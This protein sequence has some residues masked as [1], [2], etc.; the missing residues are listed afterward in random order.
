MFLISKDG[1]QEKI[2]SDVRDGSYSYIN[3]Q[4]KVLFI[5]QENEL[6]EF[7]NGKEKVKLAKDVANFDGDYS[8]D[9]VT[10]QNE[11]TDLYIINGESEKEK[12]SS[13]VSQ[14][15]LIGEHI[16]FLDNDGDLSKYN[17]MIT[18]RKKLQVM[19]SI[20]QA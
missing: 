11:E 15:E 17:T 4:D 12:I 3:S 18:K 2:A 19:F 14:Y 20:L 8:E 9:I 5:N 10:F 13:T 16:Y 7:E 6:Y 1:K